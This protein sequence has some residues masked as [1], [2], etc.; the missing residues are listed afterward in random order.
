MN[1]WNFLGFIAIL[2]KKHTFHQCWYVKIPHSPTENNRRTESKM[3]IQTK[4]EVSDSFSAKLHLHL[5][6][7][8]SKM[9]V[10]TASS[11]QTTLRFVTIKKVASYVKCPKIGTKIDFEIFCAG[12]VPKTRKKSCKF[13]Y[14]SHE[15][16]VTY[17]I[18]KLRHFQASRW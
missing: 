13:L 12:E 6:S 9:F 7:K 18:Y 1:T 3:S 4:K 16:E 8:L 2:K 14:W 17:E 5:P 10:S 15:V 11:I